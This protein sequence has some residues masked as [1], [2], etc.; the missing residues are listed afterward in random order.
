MQPFAFT[1]YT[2]LLQDIFYNLI[3][4]IVIILRYRRVLCEVTIQI[5]LVEKLSKTSDYRCFFLRIVLVIFF[6][7]SK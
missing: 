3:V 7:T 2:N 6:V 4:S 5:I 1:V